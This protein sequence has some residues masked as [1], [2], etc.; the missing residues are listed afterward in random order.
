VLGFWAEEPCP[1]WSAFFKIS[2]PW[3]TQL[4]GPGAVTGTDEKALSRRGTVYRPIGI[5]SRPQAQ[6]IENKPCWQ[7]TV[8]PERE[9][10]L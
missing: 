5:F 1:V 6:L 4:Y 10:G 9:M 2:H 8:G 7:N 3:V